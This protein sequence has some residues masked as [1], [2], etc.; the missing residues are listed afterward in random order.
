MSVQDALAE[1]SEEKLQQLK[2]DPRKYVASAWVHPNDQQRSYDFKTTD[3]ERSLHY[4]LDPH[5]PLNPSQWGGINVLLFGRGLLKTTTMQMILAWAF[6]FYGPRGLESYLAAPREDQIHE[7]SEKFKEK[8]GWTGLDQYREKNALDHQHFEFSADDRTVYAD[9]KAD[10]GWGKGDAMRGPH[11]HIGIYDEF[12]DASQRSFNAGFYEVVDQ[13]LRGVPYFPTIFV[14]GT[15]KMEGSFFDELW[16]KSDQRE[17]HPN[18]GENGEWVQTDDP[19]TYGEGD[20]AVAVHGWHVSQQAAPLHSAADIQAKR[21]LKTEQEFKNEVLAEFY[22][23]EDHLL[24]T[25]HLDACTDPEAGFTKT[26]RFDDSFVTIGVDWGGGDDRNAADTVMVAHEHLD[27]ETWVSNVNFVDDDA[28][29]SAELA[30]LEEL[31]HNFDADRVVV[32][33]GY[34]STRREDLQQGNGTELDD[35]YDQVVGVRFGNISGKTK[36]KDDTKQNLL[37]AHKSHYAKRFVDY[38]KAGRLTIPTAT[39]DPG[40]QGNPNGVGTRLWSHLTSPYETKG[41][42]KS[43]K[44]KTSIVSDSGDNDDAFDANLYAWLAYHADDVGPTDTRVEF[45][46]S[47]APGV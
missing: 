8:L 36:W 34:G 18:R 38:V 19:A 24:S 16:Q 39:V 45:R 15:P 2:H 6:Q 9:Y 1:A 28:S 46:T 5:S 12:Q 41:E 7:F 20:D 23:P 21:E 26:R 3:G 4:L 32:D 40:T 44:K 29:K 31:I 14:M 10:S 25:R 47:T 30:E 43:G 35:G 13:S 17:W 37:T 11:C 27:D 33:E 42:T 22:S